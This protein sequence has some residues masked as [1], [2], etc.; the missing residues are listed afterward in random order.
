MGYWLLSILTFIL[1]LVI[2]LLIWKIKQL[3]AEKKKLLTEKF[4]IE[5]NWGTVTRWMENLYQGK[6]IVCFLKEHKYQNIAIYGIGYLG[7]F[8]FEE[9]KDI[10]NIKCIV[11]KNS[12][13]NSYK[14]VKVIRPLELAGNGDID[15]IIVTPVVFYEEIFEDLCSLG[16]DADSIISLEDILFS[17]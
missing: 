8:L 7:K 6:R 17:L 12:K 14:G 16:C 10:I 11:D 3:S 1:L 5:K 15:V 13:L 9:I 4:R 2:A